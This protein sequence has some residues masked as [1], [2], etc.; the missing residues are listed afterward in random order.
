MVPQQLLHLT[1]SLESID[2]ILEWGLL[3]TYNPTEILEEVL[4]GS[5]QHISAPAP[6][7]MVCFTELLYAEAKTAFAPRKYGISVDLKW[8]TEAGA[9]RVAYVDPKTE[10]TFTEFRDSRLNDL[11][12]SFTGEITGSEDLARWLI[13][14]AAT[15]PNFAKSFG[16]EDEFRELQHKALWMQTIGHGE[17]REWRLR[18]PQGYPNIE[19]IQDRKKQVEMLL[20]MVRNIPQTRP[21]LALKIPRDAVLGIHVPQ[22][23]A[24]SAR[25]VVKKYGY[26]ERVVNP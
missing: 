21:T 18:S 17:E 16:L 23:R 20:R 22:G 4:G 13:E 3:Y 19:V 10:A 5:F 25:Q 9:R 12:S 1:D 2:S 11:K 24:G 14:L 15:K 26:S 6:G 8:A 7:G